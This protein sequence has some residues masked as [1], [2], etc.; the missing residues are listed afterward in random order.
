MFP[1]LGKICVSPNA[2]DNSAYDPSHNHD[3]TTERIFGCRNMPNVH[4]D[5]IK[6]PCINHASTEG[7]ATM[8]GFVMA[9]RGSSRNGITEM[10]A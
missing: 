4:Q 6:N 7:D 2:P 8:G 10:S 1:F 3:S 5:W 9:A